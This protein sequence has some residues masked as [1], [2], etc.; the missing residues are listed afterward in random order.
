MTD[1]D[2][3]VN[4]KTNK[5]AATANAHRG[6]GVLAVLRKN[7]SSFRKE[8]KVKRLGVFGSYV[9]REQKRG[10]DLDILIDFYEKPS[11]LRFIALEDYLSRLTGKKVDLVM[12]SALKPTIGKH[13]LAE[14]IYA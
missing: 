11:L 7:L 13:I 5:A 2:C 1:L 10:S 14:V 12:R 8:Y 6:D 9:R 3:L 4:R